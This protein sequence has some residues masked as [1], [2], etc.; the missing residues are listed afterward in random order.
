MNISYNSTASDY[1]GGRVVIL[2]LLFALAIY[3]FINA[4]FSVFAVI[5]ILPVLVL[6]ALVFFRKSTNG[7]WLLFIVNYFLQFAGRFRYLPPSIPM[8]LYNE[9]LELMILLTAIITASNDPKF[10]RSLNFML[11]ATLLWCTFGILEVFNDTCGIGIDVGAWFSG[12][13]LLCIQLLWIQLVFTV[14]ISTPETLH[15]YIKLWAWLSLFAAFWTF[16]QKFFG[17]T[18]TENVWL[19]TAGRTHILNGGTLIRYFSVFSDAACYG[20]NAAATAAAFFILSITSKVK[21]DRIFYLITALIVT[22]GMFQSGTRTAIFCLALGL[23]VFIL[24]S[25]S[26]KIAIVSGLVF[27][28]LGFLLV[29][30]TIGNGN[31]QIRRMRSGFNKDDASTNVRAQNQAVMKKYLA[32]APWG[33][34]IGTGMNNVPANNKFRKLSTMPPD[35]EYVF[36]WI[37]TGVIGISVFLVAMAIMFIGASRVVLF[38]LKNRS[39]MGIGAAFT[40]AFAAIQLGGYGNQVLFQ[41]PNGTIFFGAIAIV[42]TL[43]YIEPAWEEYEAK[44]VK[45]EEE[46]KR[47]KE[48]KRLAKRV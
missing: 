17:F 2:L 44:R 27:G 29:F 39:L 15:K 7:I 13:R 1:T 43:P 19:M 20:C 42:F 24:L 23:M 47:L 37:R 21:K 9:A 35:S 40:S 4:G 5:C 16:K 32:D 45:E 18:Q 30:T 22:W 12:F 26:F 41:Y 48:E 46:K 10:G 38:Q 31:Q 11:F 36:V 6:V 3:E 28:A 14:Y 34:G 33:I 25:K 8:S